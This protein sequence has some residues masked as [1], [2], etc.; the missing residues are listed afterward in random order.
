[1]EELGTLLAFPDAK[2]RDHADL[3]ATVEKFSGC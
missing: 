2:A 1:V 3:H